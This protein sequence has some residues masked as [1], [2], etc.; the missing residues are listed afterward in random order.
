MKRYKGKENGKQNRDREKRVITKRQ[1]DQTGKNTLRKK[2]RKGEQKSN[3]L[4]ESRV[5]E[6][7]I[8]MKHKRGVWTKQ[9]ERG[10]EEREL[11]T[12]NK[13]IK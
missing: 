11:I 2:G 9:R 3:K 4:R 1:K 7:F 6:C 12:E 5:S 13:R 10:D 8:I